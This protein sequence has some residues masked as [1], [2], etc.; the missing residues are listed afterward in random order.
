MKNLV[1]NLARFVSFLVYF[2][3]FAVGFRD[4]LFINIARSRGKKILV[5][6]LYYRDYNANFYFYGT[7]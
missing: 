4:R 1:K 7:I 5:N 6:F 2:E 3:A